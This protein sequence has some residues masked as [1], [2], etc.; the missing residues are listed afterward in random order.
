MNNLTNKHEFHRIKIHA[1]HGPHYRSLRCHD[2]NKHIMHLSESQ[3]HNIKDDVE[4]VTYQ[5]LDVNKWLFES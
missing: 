5:E 3:Y 2:C 4:E 1:G